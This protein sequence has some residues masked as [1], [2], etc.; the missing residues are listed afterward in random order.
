MKQEMTFAEA[1]DLCKN[2]LECEKRLSECRGHCA[3][4][5]WDYRTKDFRQAIQIIVENLE[6]YSQQN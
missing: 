3:M 1:I 4:C 5:K 6:P 2:F